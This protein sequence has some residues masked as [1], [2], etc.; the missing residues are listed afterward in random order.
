[1]ANRQNREHQNSKHASVTFDSGSKATPKWKRQET[2]R[3]RTIACSRAVFIIG[4]VPHSP[5]RYTFTQ[6]LRQTLLSGWRGSQLLSALLFLQTGR[7][8]KFNGHIA[9]PQTSIRDVKPPRRPAHRARY[10]QLSK[11][12][13]YDVAR[14]RNENAAGN[15]VQRDKLAKKS[16]PAAMHRILRQA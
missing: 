7:A 14:G 2:G 11:L 6:R 10:I 3:R 1:M 15:K 4:A 12:L 9:V 8:D 13:S 5:A 16:A